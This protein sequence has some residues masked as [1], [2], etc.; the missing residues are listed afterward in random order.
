[1]RADDHQDQ[2]TDELKIMRRELAASLALSAPGNA[3]VVITSRITVIDDE[4]ASCAAL[5]NR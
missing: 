5:V 3:R 2:T 4:L 1:M